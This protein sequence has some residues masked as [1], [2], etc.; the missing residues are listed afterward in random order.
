MLFEIKYFA[1][2]AGLARRARR[3]ELTANKTV[4]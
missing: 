1:K 2:F 3:L 4:S